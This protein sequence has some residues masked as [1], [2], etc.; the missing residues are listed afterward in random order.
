MLSKKVNYRYMLYIYGA[1][2]FGKIL[3]GFFQSKG[4]AFEFIDRFSK[5]QTLIGRPVRKPDDIQPSVDDEVFNTVAAL[6]LNARSQEDLEKS[7]KKIGFSHVKGFKEISEVFPNAF[8]ELASD[9]QFWR[10]YGDNNRNFWNE[11]LCSEFKKLLL[12]NRSLSLF[13]NIRAFRRHPSFETYIWPDVGH[14]YTEAQLDGFPFVN[15][16]KVVDLGAFNGDTVEDF[17]NHY[18]DR[19]KTFYCFEPDPKNVQQIRSKVE[20]WK[21][22]YP[23]FLI[24]CFPYA[25]GRMNGKVRFSSDKGSTGSVTQTGDIEIDCVSLD[26]QMLNYDINYIKFDIEGGEYDALMGGQELIK[27][28]KPHLAVSLYH[29]PEDF[30]R[31]PLL[32]KDFM[33]DCKMAI[34][35]HHHWGLELT[36][37]VWP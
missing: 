7:I 33:P 8:K 17:L 10:T 31:L 5:L 18:Q 36:L 37:Y 28:R 30:W 12:D 6:P 16:L 27:S 32:I 19:V 4:L 34:R 14:Q 15:D 20:R 1:G 13:E 9:G 22:L 11:E 3:G 21:S 25:V 2:H 35:Q 24:E 26:S 23:H 29:L